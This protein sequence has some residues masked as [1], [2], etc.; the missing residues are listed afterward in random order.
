MTK[1]HAS[2]VIIVVI[3]ILGQKAVKRLLQFQ[4]ARPAAYYAKEKHREKPGQFANLFRSDIC[5]VLG[6]I[7]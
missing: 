6:R 4:V 7:R 3:I 1:D 5:A 2:Q